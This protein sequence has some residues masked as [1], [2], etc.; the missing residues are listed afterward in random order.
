MEKQKREGY[1]FDVRDTSPFYN[2]GKGNFEEIKVKGKGQAPAQTN[3]VEPSADDI[4]CVF[5]VGDEFSQLTTQKNSV[6]M[7]LMYVSRS[8]TFRAY[9]SIKYQGNST[10]NFPKKNF[11]IKLFSDE[12]HKDKY[13]VEFRNWPAYNKFV[14]KANWIDVTQARNVVN[15]RIWSNVVRDREDYDQLP[16]ELTSTPNNGAID[17]F[18]VK[19]YVNGV[20]QGRYTW[21][22]GKDDIMFG[23]DCKAVICGE[24]YVS[25]CFRAEST[26][27]D[28]VDWSV[29][30]PDVSKLEEDNDVEG[31]KELE[32]AKER[33]NTAIDI[34][35]GQD[36]AAFKD[37][38]GKFIDVQS[39]IDYE[40]FGRITNHVDGFGKNQ[41]FSY[42]GGKWYAGAY[43]M[44][45][46][47]GVYW[48]GT[49]AVS[50]TCKFQSEYETGV[51]GTSNLLYDMLDTVFFD[52]IYARYKELRKSSLSEEAL[53]AEYEKFMSICPN[54]LMAEDYA[55]TTG[56]GKFTGIPYKTTNNIQRLRDHIVKRC[57][58]CDSAMEEAYNAF[59][60]PLAVTAKFNKVFGTVTL[61]TNAI[62]PSMVTIRYT[63]D[64]STPDES[65][66][67]YA[68]P[69]KLSEGQ[70]IKAV[71]Y[72]Q[73]EAPSDVVSQNYQ[74]L[75]ELD[76]LYSL[77]EYTELRSANSDAIN[78]GVKL[79]ETDK[80]FQVL[81]NVTVT[82]DYPLP[83][84]TYTAPF[85]A[86]MPEVD[87][88]PGL[89]CGGSGLWN[90]VQVV[91]DKEYRYILSTKGNIN[92]K[93]LVTHK[94]SGTYDVKIYVNNARVSLG[95]QSTHAFGTHDL[96][97]LLGATWAGGTEASGMARWCD[98]DINS[99][100]IV[101]TAI[102]DENIIKEAFNWEI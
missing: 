87:P 41:L 3:K 11:S 17:G 84:V 37:S 43:D 99:C 44:D 89:I 100:L 45:V 51:Q 102:E 69:V 83:R 86:C 95:T 93:Y 39:I 94:G 23:K 73:G 97:C 60:A 4:P 25:G 50:E 42:Y 49:K 21:N 81:L 36:A 71:A 10:L 74:T 85:L 13:K 9:I 62:S 53:I 82:E 57:A 8:K 6:N 35:I 54:D 2:Y 46:T 19:V 72:C 33:F 63:L 92:L 24:N 80:P 18:M 5:L 38:I 101:G 67:V 96:P 12:S 26:F 7:R 47:L 15:A 78:T 90:A 29:E 65:S 77:G 98:I 27:T 48:N 79:Y 59:T 32:D 88:W 28:G 16:K 58:Y 61:T 31:L 20:Y 76:R 14:L 40:I 91:A 75:Y 56:G 68:H 66:A 22:Y 70:T 30:Y 34:C 52:K 55:S 1:S 64:G